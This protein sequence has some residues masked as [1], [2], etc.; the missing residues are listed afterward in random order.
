LY[1]KFRSYDGGVSDV[2][3]I[4]GPTAAQPTTNEI[5]PANSGVEQKEG[6]KFTRDLR[7]G[8]TGEDVKELQKFLNAN[9]YFVGKTGPGSLGSETT[10][11]GLLTKQALAKWQKD[12]KLPAFG[13]FGVLTR[14]I[15]NN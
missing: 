13:F 8:M 2:F 4:E 7:Q 14:E 15:V 6:Y 10:K 11:F 12:N 9:G 3:K 1:I 5:L